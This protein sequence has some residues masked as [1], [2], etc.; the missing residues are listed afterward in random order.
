MIVPVLNARKTIR[1]TIESIRRFK[2]NQI[3]VIILD[4]GSTDGTQDTLSAS[5]DVIDILRSE[6]D[7]GLYDA[8]N[9]GVLL[10]HGIWCIFLGADDIL[11]DGFTVA[12]DALSSTTSNYYA[13]VKLASNGTIY[14]RR[15]TYLKL[16]TSNLPHQAVFYLVE[17]LKSNPFDLRYKYLADYA[18]NLLLYARTTFYYIDCVVT[19][20]NDETGMSSTLRDQAFARDKG[21]LV[22]RS[23]WRFAS[24]YSAARKVRLFLS[25]S[26]A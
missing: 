19:L 1:D 8:M 3:E 14:N 11:L 12:V 21:M 26:Q 5:M 16:L 25:G 6:P 17:V 4:G 22:S 7:R 15:Y 2:T 18:I 10:A 13:N 24:L 9:K 20:Y 23:G